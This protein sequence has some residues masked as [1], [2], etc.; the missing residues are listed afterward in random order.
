M[1]VSKGAKPKPKPIAK[2]R[3]KSVIPKR[4]RAPGKT[5]QSREKQLIKLATDLAEKRMKDGTATA[6]VIIH[7]LK[8]GTI[9]EELAREKLKQENLLLQAK[10]DAYASA[11]RLEEIYLEA[12]NAMRTYSGRQSDEIDEDD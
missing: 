5:L 3:K 1:P 10:T 4:D 2:G 6:Q 7:Y 9:T 8:L 12:L 11:K